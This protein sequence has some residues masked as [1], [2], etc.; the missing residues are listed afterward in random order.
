MGARGEIS[1]TPWVRGGSINHVQAPTHGVKKPF[2]EPGGVQKGSQLLA[3]VPRGPDWLKRVAGPQEGTE[4]KQATRIQGRQGS[5]VGNSTLSARPGPRR[6]PQV[7]LQE[8]SH[9]V[10]RAVGKTRGVAGARR[11]H[12]GC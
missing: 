5:F 9:P 1:T 10:P 3:K 8:R 7:P 11:S 6:A 12:R 2:G 4:R